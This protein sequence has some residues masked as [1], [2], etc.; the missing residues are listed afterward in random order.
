MWTP[1]L[2]WPV[3]AVA[4]GPFIG[5]FIAVLSSRMPEGRPVAMSRSACDHCGRTLSAL[6]LVPVLSFI[7]QRGRCRG[8]GGRIAPRHLY[9]ELAGAV[10]P[11]WAAFVMH[12]PLVMI[13][14]ALG[15]QLLLLALLDGEHFWLPRAATLPLIASGLA[16]AAALGVDPLFHHALG[17]TIGFLAIT[18][19][20]AV[21][22][23]IRGRDG[24][25]G[26]DAYLTAGAGAWVGWWGLPSVL[27][28]AALSGICALLVARAA[29]R[30]VRADTPAPF[31]VFLAI[32]IWLTWLYGPIGVG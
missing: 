7:A 4:L 15:W 19:I 2:F 16:V 24:L 12:G 8:C 31:G 21:Y 25:G 28:I 6:E 27:V 22:K 18:A 13:G 30:T 26:G 10:P 1:D 11:V 20:A 23:R 3:V 14:A 29:G 5:S 9:I 32:G 17:A